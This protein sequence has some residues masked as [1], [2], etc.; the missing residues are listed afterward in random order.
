MGLRLAIP[1]FPTS[2]L[3]FSLLLGSTA[4]RSQ[5]PP[6]A[7]G[8]P[9]LGFTLETTVRWVL[10]P[11]VV[12][13]AKG[14]SVD[15]LDATDFRLT[16]E[17]R[18]VE[19]ESFESGATGP[20]SLVVLQDVSGSMATVGRLDLSRRVLRCILASTRSDDELGLASFASDRTRVDVPLTTD[21]GVVRETLEAWEGYGTTALHD[22]VAWLP[23][24]R[25]GARHLK[26]GALLLTDGVDNA[27]VGSAEEARSIVA[28][29]ELPVHV[30]AL[31]ERERAR[32]P[33]R[34]LAT[35]SILRTLSV[36][37]SGAY[38]RVAD[39][40]DALA[41]CE[42]IVRDLRHQYVLGFREVETGEERERTLSVTVE[43]GKLRV[44]HRQ[45]YRG[46]APAR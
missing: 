26:S 3:L 41:A 4:A 39:D 33:G 10:V 23:E 1:L 46:R 35:S 7:T 32:E 13:N 9:E 37:T 6:D 8:V 16:V 15:D 24:L 5:R 25:R 40:D 12:E 30:V 44:H 28:R 43:S 42:S 31:Q 34:R 18:P 14:A 11:V 22:A 20:F 27:S 2:L 36:A 17:D 21:R 45:G 38:H 29:A 19:I